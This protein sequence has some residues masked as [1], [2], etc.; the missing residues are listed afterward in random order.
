LGRIGIKVLDVLIIRQKKDIINNY[1]SLAELRALNQATYGAQTFNQ[2]IKEVAADLTGGKVIEQKTMPAKIGKVVLSAEQ[3]KKLAKGDAIIITGLIDK[4]G[5]THT[6]NIRWNC[7]NN[8]IEFINIKQI[9]QNRQ[10][11]NVKHKV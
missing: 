8:K 10:N 11:R 6:S 5:K 3:R 2:V 4:S 9:K 7:Q 1:I